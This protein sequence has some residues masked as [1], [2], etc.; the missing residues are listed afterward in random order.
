MKPYYITFIALAVLF[1]GIWLY[2][3]LSDSK[4]V[5]SARPE[6]HVAAEHQGVAS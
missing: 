3:T 6:S 5:D 1:F 2:G 4:H